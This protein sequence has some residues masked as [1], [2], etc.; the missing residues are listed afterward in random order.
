[1]N[2]GK[3]LNIV[4]QR[5]PRN[6]ERRQTRAPRQRRGGLQTIVAFNSS[7]VAWCYGVHLTNALRST[8]ALRTCGG[9]TMTAQANVVSRRTSQRLSVSASCRSNGSGAPRQMQEYNLRRQLMS[10]VQKLII[11]ALAVGVAVVYC[12]GCMVLYVGSSLS[13]V[14]VI[15]TQV[16]TP[17]VQPS[18][19]ELP[20]PTMTMYPTEPRPTSPPRIV[21]LGEFGSGWSCSRSYQASEFYGTVY[22]ETGRTVRFVK[23]RATLYDSEKIS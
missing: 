5:E 13:E 12:I 15:P 4:T 14:R 2:F 17:T 18:A 20:R 1:M 22:N 10:R 23:I 11:A 19:T 6:D 3:Q 21:R 7:A 9:R 8:P 16:Q